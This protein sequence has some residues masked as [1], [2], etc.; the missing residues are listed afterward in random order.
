MPKTK[1][2]DVVFTVIM[3]IVMVYA[4]VCYNIAIANEGMSNNVFLYAFSEMPIMCIIA[5]LLEFFFVG[6]V[7]KNIAFKILNP[8][9]TQPIFIIL[10]ISSLTVCFMCPLM[11][12]FATILFN[13]SGVSNVIPTW[14]GITVR[15]FPMALFWQI[16][17]A[18]PFVRFVFKKIFAKQLSEN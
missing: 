14:L 1:F 15:N 3:V 6:R 13:Y 2:Q 7:T 4:M 5:F 9:Q 10:A 17:Y 18:G 16:F 8:A 11:S 12:F